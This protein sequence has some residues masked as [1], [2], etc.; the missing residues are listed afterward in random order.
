MSGR[1][2]TP[3]SGGALAL[4]GEEKLGVEDPV[5]MERLADA[6][7]IERVATRWIVSSDPDEHVE[8]IWRYVEMG[9]RHLVFH[10]P[11]PDQAGFLGRYE[12][13]I[14]PRLRERAGDLCA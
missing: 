5:E 7:P 8:A 10:A 1:S 11:G 4:S 2:T 3:G 14:L 9:F 12:S 6:L 13:S